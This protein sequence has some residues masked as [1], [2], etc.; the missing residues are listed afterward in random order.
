MSDF[1]IHHKLNMSRVFV[2]V[3]RKGLL[4]ESNRNNHLEFA[5]STMRY[6]QM[7]INES[8]LATPHKE[9]YVKKVKLC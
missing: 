9:A 7:R 4:S 6:S 3:A 1:K 2:Q 5:I 8:F